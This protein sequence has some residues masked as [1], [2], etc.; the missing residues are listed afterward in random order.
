MPRAAPKSRRRWSSFRA[1]GMSAQGMPPLL[2]QLGRA[3]LAATSGAEQ[4]SI[5]RQLAALAAFDAD[6]LDLRLRE[7]LGLA[8]H[9]LDAWATGL[10]SQA[11]DSQRDARPTGMQIGGY[12]WVEN[13]RRDKSVRAS[14]G[15]V[16]APS[17]AHAA[18]AAVL[19]AGWQAFGGNGAKPD[20]GLAVRLEFGTG[21][22]RPCAARRPACG[23]SARR[24]ARPA[25]RANLHDAALD[26]W[27]DKLRARV[28][29]ATATATRASRSTASRCGTCG[30]RRRAS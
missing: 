11:L 30:A 21:A 26:V 27:I 24:A 19:R 2:F 7:T 16:L 18:S 14:Q 28:A 23:Q 5:R 9:R 1:S 12:G 13:L 17:L 6:E 3:A 10:A 4:D 20:P 8:T 25:H 22:Y 29:A 15:H